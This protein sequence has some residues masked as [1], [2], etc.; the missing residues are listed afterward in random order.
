MLLGIVHSRVSTFLRGGISRRKTAASSLTIMR[1]AES[2]GHSRG[3]LSGGS[4][5]TQWPLGAFSGGKPLRERRWDSTFHHLEGNFL[6]PE[7]IFPYRPRTHP[8]HF[9]SLF[10][11]FSENHSRQN[12]HILMLWDEWGPGAGQQTGAG[13]VKDHLR[14]GS[15]PPDWPWLPWLHLS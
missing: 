14:E 12:Q 1:R 9:R 8:R 13:R 6:R 5:M 15:L 4:G 2:C 11:R 3:V 7:S 10:F